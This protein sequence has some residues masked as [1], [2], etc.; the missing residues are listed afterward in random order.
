MSDR[1]T[2]QDTSVE[3]VDNTC[4]P[5]AH[6]HIKLNDLKFVKQ[7][8]GV[9][10]L[11]WGFGSVMQIRNSEAVTITLINAETVPFDNVDS[12]KSIID[13]MLLKYPL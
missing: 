12:V 5:T 6:K 3:I 9:E 11:L 4:T 7:L 1:I 10:D 2:D 13:K 8:G